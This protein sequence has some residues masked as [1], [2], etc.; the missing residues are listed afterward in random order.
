[1]WQENEE[2]FLQFF[3]KQENKWQY[4]VRFTLE[5]KEI[6]DF[7]WVHFINFSCLYIKANNFIQT[8]PAS[9]FIRKSVACLIGPELK[10]TLAGNK[11]IVTNV[12]TGDRQETEVT[13]EEFHALLKSEFG[14]IL[15]DDN[16]KY[17]LSLEPS[18]TAPKNFWSYL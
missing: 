17:Q 7:E 4:K 16:G 12:Q 18:K 3:D 11:Y 5:P 14:I 9:K 1:M 13:L 8:D 10:K 6:K 15:D 2:Y